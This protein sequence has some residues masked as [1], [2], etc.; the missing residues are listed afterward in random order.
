M[1]RDI[2]AARQ[3][4][5]DDPLIEQVAQS[6]LHEKVWQLLREHARCQEVAEGAASTA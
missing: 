2:E 4:P 1:R 5:A 3:L 6:K